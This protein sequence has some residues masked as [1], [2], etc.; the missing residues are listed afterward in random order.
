MKKYLLLITLLTIQFTIQAQEKKSDATIE[1]TQ[2]FLKNMIN[3]NAK[4]DANVEWA[5][6][7]KVKVVFNKC[8]V[9]FYKNKVDWEVRPPT[10]TDEVE[11]IIKFDLSKIS[12]LDRFNFGS[13]HGLTIKSIVFNTYNS[14]KNIKFYNSNNVLLSTKSKFY[15]GFSPSDDE[16]IKR[17]KKAF[18]HLLKLCD[19]GKKEK[20]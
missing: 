6:R 11:E 16:T 13:E 1:E 2:E 18:N 9:D 20:F 14:N 12:R 7:G 17:V 5:A 4:S 10:G 8:F 19:G 3:Q 15:L